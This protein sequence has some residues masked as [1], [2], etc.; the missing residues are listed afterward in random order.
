[1]PEIPAGLRRNRNPL[2]GFLLHRD[3]P[4]DFAPGFCFK[5]PRWGI[6]RRRTNLIFP[7]VSRTLHRLT[8][9]ALPPERILTQPAPYLS[10]LK[11][12][13]LRS[14]LIKKPALFH[15]PRSLPVLRNITCFQTHIIHTEMHSDRKSGST[16]QK[17]LPKTNIL[18]SVLNTRKTGSG[19]GFQ[20]WTN[21]F[22]PTLLTMFRLLI[23]PDSTPAS[24][25]I[26]ALI[27]HGFLEA[28]ASSRA[29]FSSAGVLT[30]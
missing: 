25:S 26:M 13:V 8:R 1:M 16:K 20:S 12:F 14:I 29:A 7:Q 9:H 27:R 10:A 23:R 21:Y 28:T 24:G 4:E 3:C 6:L 11:G 30:R 2:G 15:A 5:F 22:L 19:T 17:T 18:R